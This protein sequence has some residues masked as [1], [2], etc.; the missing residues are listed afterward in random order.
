MRAEEGERAGRPGDPPFPR[1]D[2]MK[3]LPH[4]WM[5]MV[6]KNGS[7]LHRCTELTKC[8]SVLRVPPRHAAQCQHEARDDDDHEAGKAGDAEDVDPGGDIDRLPIGSHWPLGTRP[9][10][11]R[12]RAAVQVSR[13]RR[14]AGLSRQGRVRRRGSAHRCSSSRG[15]G[16]GSRSAST[17]TRI[18]QRMTTR[19][20]TVIVTHPHWTTGPAGT[21]VEQG[22]QLGDHLWPPEAR[23]CEFSCPAQI[24]YTP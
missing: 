17:K 14:A 1:Q 19:L 2:A 5:T 16:N 23:S 4:R 18:I 21:G 8:P 7:T 10:T 12:V 6:A 13:P 15:S 22:E 20:A 9:S 11:H 24:Y 3:N